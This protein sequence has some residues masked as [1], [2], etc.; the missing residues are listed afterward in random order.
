MSEELV[1]WEG[2]RQWFAT[3]DL[4]ARVYAEYFAE[5]L[6]TG[7]PEPRRPDAVTPA[8][9]GEIRKRLRREWNRRVWAARRSS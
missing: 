7:A 4:D 8:L 9:A 3:L 6:S 1:K 5:H 2:V